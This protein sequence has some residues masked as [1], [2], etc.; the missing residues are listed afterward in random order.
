MES[1]ITKIDLGFNCQE[2]YNKM[3]PIK[4]GK[5]CKSCEKMV[6]DFTNFTTTEILYYFEQYQSKTC[7][8]ISSDQLN[9]V[10]KQIKSQNRSRIRKFSKGLIT[11]A[12]L[13]T[14][15][16]SAQQDTFGV[17]PLT[18]EVLKV[19]GLPNDSTFIIKG[20][21]LTQNTI[22]EPLIGAQVYIPNTNQGSVTDID[23]NFEIKLSKNLDPS[24]TLETSYLGFDSNAM[25]IKEFVAA[26][27][28][29]TLEENWT[30]LGDIVITQQPLRRRI[31]NRIKSWF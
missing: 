27:G 20:T 24:I 29:I 9:R 22:S 12:L 19:P 23:G 30:L 3:L 15:S 8:R 11:S 25:S 16:L 31:W 13:Y 4:A 17:A 7:G 18:I 5:H 21:V 2:D 26:K 14:T 10:N 28:Q 6:I 1:T